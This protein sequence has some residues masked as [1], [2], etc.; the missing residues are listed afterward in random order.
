M[1]FSVLQF[2]SNDTRKGRRGIRFCLH[3]SLWLLTLN[4]SHKQSKHHYPPFYLF[5]LPSIT[6]HPLRSRPRPKEGS[7]CMASY[8]A[9][10]HSSTPSVGPPPS[11]QAWLK[12]QVSGSSTFHAR[13][14]DP[15][16]LPSLREQGA[17]DP[18]GPQSPQAMHIKWWPGPTDFN[19][20]KLLLLL[21]CRDGTWA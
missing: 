1:L 18:A 5:K 15:A 6:F 20:G 10:E 16:Q 19:P 4:K 17:R 3:A 11:A 9:R 13:S 14:P 7:P 21:G 12:R 2:F 8:P